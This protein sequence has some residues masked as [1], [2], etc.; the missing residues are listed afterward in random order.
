MSNSHSSNLST[1]SKLLLGFFIT[2]NLAPTL[3]LEI[4]KQPVQVQRNFPDN[5]S[6]SKAKEINE[7]Y[8]PEQLG[9]IRKALS[10]DGYVL[11]NDSIPF[12]DKYGNE[13]GKLRVAIQYN[14][15]VHGNSGNLEVLTW[16][17]NENMTG[18]S[19]LDEIVIMPFSTNQTAISNKTFE[20]NINELRNIINYI[21]I[22]ERFIESDLC[23][24]YIEKIPNTIA[25]LLKIPKKDVDQLRLLLE[26]VKSIVDNEEKQ[27]EV[28]AG[29]I[30]AEDKVYC[31]TIIYQGYGN[32]P[33][34]GILPDLGL[35]EKAN[36]G[37]VS[38]AIKA[39][40]LR[41]ERGEE[42]T[43]AFFIKVRKRD[44]STFD[45]FGLR[46]F[47][48]KRDWYYASIVMTFNVEELIKKYD[49]R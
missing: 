48:A 36:K 10:L 49:L 44:Y 39:M 7:T 6:L 17:D 9:I 16:L 35:N 43:K 42:S 24:D 45:V 18:S 47:G 22:E 1:F 26:S 46:D 41:I 29:N 30:Y 31:N 8:S 27:R 19:G 11:F 14:P 37:K 40:R 2:T 12:L 23:Y 4:P 38:R 20:L 15:G 33:L 25:S 3:E 13:N 5:I 21:P 28:Q 34:N 32:S